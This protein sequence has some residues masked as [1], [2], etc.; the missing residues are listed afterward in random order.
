MDQGPVPRWGP[1]LRASLATA[2]VGI[3]W[4]THATPPRPDPCPLPCHL[5]ATPTASRCGFPQSTC[6]RSWRAHRA[7]RRSTTTACSSRRPAGGGGVT[8]IG[9]VACIGRRHPSQRVCSRHPVASSAGPPL[10]HA[11]ARRV[12]PGAFGRRCP[13]PR[14]MRRWPRHPSA[15]RPVQRARRTWGTPATGSA[16]RRGESWRE[17]GKGGGSTR[18][19][20]ASHALIAAQEEA[21]S[22]PTHGSGAPSRRP[23][24]VQLPPE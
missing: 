11:P 12:R 5:Q 18:A 13:A 22:P 21:A 15:A 10:P 17:G 9:R 6:N 14:T 3:A 4:T 2:G 20:P 7:G 23:A 8:S 19:G 16:W 24:A 1:R